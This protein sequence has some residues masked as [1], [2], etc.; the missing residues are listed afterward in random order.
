MGRFGAVFFG[1]GRRRCFRIG[2]RFARRLGQI[3]VLLRKRACRFGRCFDW[4]SRNCGMMMVTHQKNRIHAC[5]LLMMAARHSYQFHNCYS[6]LILCFLKLWW[7][8]H[9]DRF[10]GQVCLCLK[11]SVY[12]FTIITIFLASMNKLATITIVINLYQEV[13]S[14]WQ[15][16]C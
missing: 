7:H 2:S 6:Q 14:S 3:F 8:L 9:R 5:K 1:C 15:S 13:R 16:N 4:C 11:W 10:V 12:V